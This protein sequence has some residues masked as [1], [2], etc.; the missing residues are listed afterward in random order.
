MPL[1][2]AIEMIDVGGN[3][4]LI[5]R[6][7]QLRRRR[8]RFEPAP[9]QPADGA[10]C[11]MRGIVSAE[12]RQR[13]AA[14]ALADVAAYYAEV[15]GYLNHIAGTRFPDRL[16]LVLEKVRD[17]AYGE[18]PHQEAAFYRE[19]THRTGSLA[20]ATSSA[21]RPA[22]L[23]RPARSRRG[24]PGRDRLHGAHVLHRQAGQPDRPG[25]ERPA[26]RR[27][28]EGAR[29]RPGSAFGAVV[30]VNREVDAETAEA[31]RRQR[32]RGGRGAGLLRAGARDP[33]PEGA[34]DARCRVPSAPFEGLSDYGIARLDFQRI[35]GGLLVQT[36]DRSE[37]DRSQLQRRDAPPADARGADRPAVRVARRPPRH[38]QRRRAG[39]ATAP[40]S[41]SAP[42]RRRA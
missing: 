8:R 6:R 22:H 27:L 42:A 36:R 4:L 33:Q 9:L 41:V 20:D 37:L 14:D 28:P 21:G 30:A 19:T 38:L 17:L 25:L 16:A 31:D 23:Q 18:N 26:G 5:G 10:S 1:D 34:A 29:G 2:E 3:A 13:L 7:P 35:D 11:E 40:S 15:A 32:L 12:F 39:A 24:V